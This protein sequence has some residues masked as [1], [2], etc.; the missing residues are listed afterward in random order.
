MRHAAAELAAGGYAPVPSAAVD[1][2]WTGPSAAILGE[3]MRRFP[4]FAALGAIGP[5]LFFFLPDFRD[6]TVGGVRFPLS[7]VLN[8]VLQYLEELVDAVDPYIEKY[9]HYL[10]PH[11]ETEAEEMSRLT[12][13][14]SET[15]G[16]I[17]GEL[18]GILSTAIEDFVVTQ[19]DFW[20]YFS[21]GLNEG[22]DEQAFFWS[23]MLHYRRTG[24]FGRRLLENADNLPAEDRE[25]ARAYALGYLTHLA[26][27]VSGHAMVNAISGGPFR[28]HWQRHHLVENH[29]DAHWYLADPLSTAYGNQYPQFTESALFYDIAFGDDPKHPDAPVG[30]PVYPDGHT[31]R[32]NWARRRT[33]DQD[34]E[35]PDAIAQLLLDTIEDV[36]YQG[37]KHPKILRGTGGRP[38]EEQIK[39]AYALLY[40][41]LR[42]STL[43]GF[44][45]ERPDPPP[46]FPN[47]DFPTM[48]D[49]GHPDDPPGD[50]TFFDDLLDFL[51]SVARVLEFI[52]DWVKYIATLPWAVLADLGTYPLRWALYYCMELPLFYMLKYFRWYLVMTGYLHPMRDEISIPLI[53]VGSGSMDLWALL[54]A[55]IRDPF[56]ALAPTHDDPKAQTFRDPGYPRLNDPDDYKHPWEYPSAKTEQHPTT[57]GPY[58]RDADPATLFRAQPPDPAI[59]DALEA[60]A[61]P[62]QADLVGL[63]VSPHHHLGD[64]VQLSKYLVWLA[65]RT[66]PQAAEMVDWNLDADRGYGYHGWDWNRRQP[67]ADFPQQPDEEGNLFDQPCTWPSQAR[68]DMDP[69]AGAPGARSTLRGDPA[70]VHWS[71]EPDPGC[72]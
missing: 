27:D 47:L 51:L 23:D 5:D 30:R 67:S 12:G 56:G 68:P 33:L 6:V 40:R 34:S 43:D 18:S 16:T 60:A 1:P 10:G 29:M 64:S 62:Q 36:F 52:L 15:V 3:A 7:T 70:R 46:V 55:Q 50:G 57:A 59:R 72:Q 17:L 45:H 31:L 53:R 32:D 71:G 49:P 11:G 48:G 28:L 13:G 8:R 9:E 35:M 26:T 4:N 69:A 14:L 38:T 44:S 39:E 42:L 41:Y 54:Q 37:G 24:A 66:D 22:T 58:A 63:G 65:S 19:V 20:K 21:L 61:T 25:G 2:G